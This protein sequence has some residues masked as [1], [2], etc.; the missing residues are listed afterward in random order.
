M[1][2]L[3]DAHIKKGGVGSGFEVLALNLE[4]VLEVGEFRGEVA[5]EDLAAA[6]ED[7]HRFSGARK[8]RGC[9]AAAVA[10]SDNDHVVSRFQRVERARQSGHG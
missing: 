9:N 7:G 3:A 1:H 4:V 8:V 6:F 10:G 2:V 5:G